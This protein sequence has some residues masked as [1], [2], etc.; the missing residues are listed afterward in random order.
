M[1]R[2]STTSTTTTEL[3]V[4]SIYNCRF[5]SRF[6]PSGVRSDR[7]FDCDDHEIEERGKGASHGLSGWKA[8]KLDHSVSRER[9]QNCEDYQLCRRIMHCSTSCN[10]NDRNRTGLTVVM[11]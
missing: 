8:C 10:S 3:K 6:V 9:A 1:V 11:V 7:G 5:A 4:G 2:E